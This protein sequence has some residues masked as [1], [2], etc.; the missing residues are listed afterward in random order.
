MTFDDPVPRDG[1]LEVRRLVEVGRGPE[2]R[3]GPVPAV[4]FAVAVA[5]AVAE[6]V[7]LVADDGLTVVASAKAVAFEPFGR[8]AIGCDALGSCPIS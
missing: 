5:E 3:V 6:A 2:R 4:T 7:P 1:L 8:P